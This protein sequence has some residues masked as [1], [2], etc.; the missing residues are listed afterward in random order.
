[1]TGVPT[2]FCLS[3]GMADCKDGHNAE[4]L[5]REASKRAGGRGVPAESAPDAPSSYAQARR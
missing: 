1:M 4:G 3:Y 2:R 5:L